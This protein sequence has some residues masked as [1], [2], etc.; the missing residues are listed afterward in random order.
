MP[1]QAIAA[2]SPSVSGWPADVDALREL[3]GEL[4]RENPVYRK[5][6]RDLGGTPR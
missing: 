6:V 1:G 3:A 2:V 4:L 5:L